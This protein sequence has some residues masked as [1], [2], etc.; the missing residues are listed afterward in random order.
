[1]DKNSDRGYGNRLCYW[2]CGMGW[3][4]TLLLLFL[5]LQLVVH[6]GCCMIHQIKITNAYTHPV[7]VSW[8]KY[9]GNGLWT[10]RTLRLKPGRTGMITNGRQWFSVEAETGE[11][12]RYSIDSFA[13]FGEESISQRSCLWFW[14]YSRVSVYLDENKYLWILPPPNT[15]K[16]SFK[17]PPNFPLVPENTSC[18][19]LSPAYVGRP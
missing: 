9:A 13:A 12:W 11:Y 19:I 16:Q 10:D 5:I 17:Q 18:K 3:E 14:G 1:M 4:K 2:V 7:V 15:Q 8:K 6:A